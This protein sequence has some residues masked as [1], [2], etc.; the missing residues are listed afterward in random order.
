M[1]EI[2]LPREE[3]NQ[4]VTLMGNDDDNPFDFIMRRIDSLR[5]DEEIRKRGEI[6]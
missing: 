6:C 5:S 2:R 1:A 3:N 4:P